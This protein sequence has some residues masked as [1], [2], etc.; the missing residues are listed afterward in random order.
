MQGKIVIPQIKYT[1]YVYIVNLIYGNTYKNLHDLSLEATVQNT[2][3]PGV[4]D[5]YRE[6]ETID[7]IR[8]IV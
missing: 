8:I 3:N 4:C 7:M 2:K 6:H 1:V 5:F